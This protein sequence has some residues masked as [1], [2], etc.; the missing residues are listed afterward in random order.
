MPRLYK[1]VRTVALPPGTLLP[2]EGKQDTRIHL[3]DYDAKRF[4]ERELESIEESFAYKESDTVSWINIDGRDVEV[5][6][7]VDE[8]YGI[9]PLVLEDI[10]NLGQRPK[11]E[12]YGDYLFLVLKMIYLD[13][14]KNDI[15]SEQV[16]LVLGKN[17]VISFQE[18]PGGD[19]FEP[20]RSRIRE[21]KG[22][23]RQMEADYLVYC[24]LD[25]I[26]DNYFVIL[27]RIGEKID[28]LE[29]GILDRLSDDIPHRI[30]R[31]KTK[32][33]YLRK[34]IWPLREV[35]ARFQRN[36]FPLIRK[37]TEIYLRDVYDHT[38][39][40]NDTLEAFRDTLSGLHDIYLSSISNRMNEIMKVLTM[41]AAIF[42]PLT[43]IVGIY[44]MNFENMPELKWRY[45]Y[46]TLL[47]AM[48]LLAIG[49]VGY[50][51][52]RKWL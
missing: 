8:H 10:M 40:V 29:K 11:I 7:K 19:V 13:E 35:L 41:F 18:K 23:V 47:G 38:I 2:L 24:L 36:E 39:Q 32:I 46:F 31:L 28:S 27:E 22:R 25:A 26:V 9:H 42:I 17:F 15:Y 6:R 34:Q 49:M 3:I 52:G 5:I 45:G 30:H 12:D 51:K 48:A 14:S 33:I 4:Q 37:T 16:G 43:F 1:K 21:A 50:F 44:G 20:I